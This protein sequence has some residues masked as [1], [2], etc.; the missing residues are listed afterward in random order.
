MSHHVKTMDAAAGKWRGILLELGA[1]E[2]ALRDRHGPCPFCGGT[3]RFRFDNRQGSG[4]F[5]CGQCGAGNGM[6]FA[7]RLT[8]QPFRDV[9]ARIDALIGNEKIGTDRPK[10][11]LTEDR[12]V[13][14]LREVAKQTVRVEKGDLV[15][16]Y[17]TAR[18]VGLSE[19]PSCLRFGSAL[20]DGEGS[21]R[22]AMVA[23]V[24][25]ADGS[26]ATLHR[27][28][29]RPDGLAK[30]EMERPRKLMPGSIPLGAAVRLSPHAG[31]PLGIAE[32]IETALAASLLYEIPVWAALNAHMLS[33]WVPPEGC[34]EVAIFADADANYAGQ[35]AAHVLANR[36]ARGGAAVIVHVPP[37]ISED[38]ND[39]LLRKERAVA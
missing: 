4:S 18:G 9:A 34:N 30:A 17:L 28:F 8:G 31:G 12:R 7:M 36:L 23:T 3:D 27:T 14:M 21:V 15:D 32:G 16:A 39:V 37:K 1:P 25:A 33:K 38:W 19:Y 24:Q 22:P 26:N 35:A 5:I 10:E 11:E 13:S 2:S 29:L 6:D 20:R